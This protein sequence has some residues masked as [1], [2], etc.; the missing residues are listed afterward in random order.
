MLPFANQLNELSR[1]KAMQS[2]AAMSLGVS[3]QMPEALASASKRKKVLRLFMNGGMSHVDFFDP[4][5]ETPEVMGNTKTI[6]TNTDET[7]SEFFPE[8]A[9]RA[10]RFAMIRSVTST[11]A[12][13]ARGYYIMETSYPVLGT[14]KHP[15]FGA[16][17]QHFN[18]VGNPNLPASITMGGGGGVDAGFL[19]KKYDPFVVN[20]P[21]A[22]LDG[23][24]MDN[25][26][27]P[28]NIKFLKLM[29]SIRTEFHKNYKSREADDYKNFY[30]D[31]IKFM[32]SEDLAAFDIT[33]EDKATIKKYNVPQ[34]DKFLLA[35]RLMQSS[36]QYVSIKMGGWDDHNNLWDAY[37]TRAANLDKVLSIFLDDLKELGM[38]DEVIFTL[39]TE[40]GRS[41]K[42]T[43]TQ[44]RGHFRR[45]FSALMGGAGVNN[46]TVYGKTNERGEKVI[47]NPVQPKDFNATIAKLV[48]ISLDQEIYS[49]DN[50]PFTVSRDGRALSGLI[51]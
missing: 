44:G 51:A 40:F 10:D 42:I 39:A 31:S 11:E 14:I 32:Q 16:W 35:R 29:S 23:L 5:P 26:Q 19:G 34:G 9:K 21:K 4:K 48:G 33:K 46:G 38:E 45:A 37:P 3:T 6:R 13:H 17:M 20:N 7:M 47:E 24:I 49:P 2:I 50:R 36:V 27:S 22:P 43:S 28:E 25:P 1:R 18:G 30:N 8:L 15:S 12:D 41:P